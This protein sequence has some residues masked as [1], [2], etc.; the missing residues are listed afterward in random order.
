VRYWDAWQSIL[1]PNTSS[2]LTLQLALGHTPAKSPGGERAVVV[3]SAGDGHVW[4]AIDAAGASTKSP[5]PSWTQL[6]VLESYRLAVANEADG[7]L[8]LFGI[9]TQHRVWNIEQT[10]FDDGAWAPPTSLGGPVNDLVVGPQK[11]GRLEAFAVSYDDHTLVHIWE[12]APNGPWA[13]E[14]PVQ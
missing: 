1:S 14:L 4:R 7:R 2:H 13:Q 5:P 8:A 3:V 11:G 12:T 10:A 6:P 9:S